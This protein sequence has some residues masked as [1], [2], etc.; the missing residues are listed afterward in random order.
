MAG[1]VHTFTVLFVFCLL[2]AKFA[3]CETFIPT[4]NNG[5]TTFPNVTRVYGEIRSIIEMANF[6]VTIS[7]NEISSFL[8]NVPIDVFNDIPVE[9][10]TSLLAVFIDDA[11]ESAFQDSSKV[12]EACL[13]DLTTFLQDL[14][15]ISSDNYAYQLLASNGKLPSVSDVYNANFQSLGDY[16][17]CVGAKSPFETKQCGMTLYLASIGITIAICSPASCSE[18][19]LKIII[20]GVKTLPVFNETSNVDISWIHVGFQCIDE[21]PWS[22]GSIVTLALLSIFALLVVLGTVHDYTIKQKLKNRNHVYEK[23]QDIHMEK[24]NDNLGYHAKESKIDLDSQEKGEVDNKAFEATEESAASSN[25]R[26]I[27]RSSSNKKASPPDENSNEKRLQTNKNLPIQKLTSTENVFEKVLLSFSATRNGSKIFDIGNSSRQLGCLNGIRV[28]SMWWVI[29]GHSLYFAIARYDNPAHVYSLA[30]DL[31]F[32][33]IVNATFS[34]DTFFVLSGLLLTY[35]TLKHLKKTNGRINWLLFYFHRFW[36][37]TPSYMMSI[38]ILSTLFVYFGKGI[39]K[40]EFAEYS[41]NTCSDY[42]WT[43]LLYINNLYPFPGSLANMCMGWSW[44]LANDMQF[45]IISPILII[46][47]YKNWKIGLPAISVL[48]AASIA[49]T[50]WISYY[51]GLPVTGSVLQGYY[52]NRT[53]DILDDRMYAKPYCRIQAFLVGM[54][55]GYI[56]YRLDKKAIKI[57][58]MVVFLGW[59]A[60]VGTGIAIV[61]GTCGANRGNPPTHE[62]AAFYNAVSRFVWSVAVGWVIFACITGYGGFVNTLLSCAFWTPLTRLNYGAYLLHPIVMYAVIYSWKTLFHFSYVNYSFFFVGSIVFS[63]V[64]SFILSILIEGPFMQLEK[65]IF[66]KAKKA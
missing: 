34:V 13:T 65:V 32:A 24:N 43:N 1:A 8:D 27:K 41:T 55:V 37:L 35:L 3:D 14:L 11:I 29:L 59:T 26:E 50:A 64:S 54:A 44:Y 2:L 46:L 60:A 57:P 10:V 33:A 42:W 23:E 5:N 49:I 20:D 56:L 62:V 15:K 53:V 17:L 39:G 51:W 38:G 25:T 30:T 66:G 12:S 36:R 22:T 19:D 63:Y 31:T 18:D 40:N 6:N 58:P 28:L 16:D 21:V 45:F 9:T 61:Y 48:C 52:N 7:E 4:N 47:L